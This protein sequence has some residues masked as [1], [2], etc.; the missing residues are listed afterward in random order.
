MFAGLPIVTF[1]FNG[2]TEYLRSGDAH[3][4]VVDMDREVGGQGGVDSAGA[5]FARTVGWLVVDAEDNDERGVAVA[6][7]RGKQIGKAAREYVRT[8]ELTTDATTAN[9][10]KALSALKLRGEH[11]GQGSKASVEVGPSGQQMLG[12][13]DLASMQAYHTERTMVQR[14]APGGRSFSLDSFAVAAAEGAKIIPRL[15][16]DYHAQWQ[17]TFGSGTTAANVGKLDWPPPDR[18]QRRGNFFLTS[19]YKLRHDAEQIRFLVLI[20]VMD[21]SFTSHADALESMS[22]SMAIE[23]SN[24]PEPDVAEFILRKNQ[25]AKL[26]GLYNRMLY[27]STASPR[28][29]RDAVGTERLPALNQGHDFKLIQEAYLDNGLVVVDNV[30]TQHTLDLLYGFALRSTVWFDVKR[31]YLGA[32]ATDGMHIPELVPQLVVELRRHAPR[33]FQ[34]DYELVNCWSYKSIHPDGLGIHADR[35]IVNVNLWVTPDSANLNSTSGGLKIWTHKPPPSAR[36]TD[37]NSR[38]NSGPLR[39]KLDEL[40]ATRVVIPYK[41]N[42]AVIFDSQFFHESDRFEFAQGYKNYRINFTLLFG[43]RAGGG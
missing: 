19:P 2:V 43:R 23:A 12:F 30:L 40:N 25:I 3:G 15:T 26:N 34:E 24:D 31:G 35:A 36:F 9:Y 39:A 10:L 5:A 1:G 6:R 33:I 4:L 41:A 38:D 14:A 16:S 32:Y 28:S 17:G 27:L 11:W 20:G 7:S 42:R 29:N 21:S 18:F 8:R 13:L 37:Y 22:V